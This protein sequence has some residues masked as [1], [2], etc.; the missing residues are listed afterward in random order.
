MPTDWKTHADGVDTAV[1]TVH[2][3]DG[4]IRTVTTQLDTFKVREWDT[5]VDADD[6]PEHAH[7]DERDGVFY[8]HGSGANA[9]LKWS[10]N[11]GGAATLES[12]TP[13]DGDRIE[14]RHMALLPASIRIVENIDGVDLAF[15]PLETLANA[16][17]DAGNVHIE[18]LDG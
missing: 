3:L 6:P 4:S 11:D 1:S 17:H 2:D 12:V 8:E 5:D 15:D 10:V 14:P 16:Y 18:K 7:W 13:E 9:T